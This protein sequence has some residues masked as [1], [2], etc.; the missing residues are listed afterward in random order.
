VLDG[1]ERAPGDGGEEVLRVGDDGSAGGA[2]LPLVDEEVQ[3]VVQ[4]TEEA[5]RV[6]SVAVHDG[7]EVGGGTS[8]LRCG[9]QLLSLVGGHVVSR[10]SGEGEGLVLR[11]NLHGGDGGVRDVLSE[12]LRGVGHDVL[13]GGSG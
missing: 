6:G 5:L 10:G 11:L 3:G 1:D 2:V 12:V 7:E 13:L 4:E 8:T 9:D